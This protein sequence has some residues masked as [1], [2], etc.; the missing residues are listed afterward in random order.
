MSRDCRALIDVGAL[1]HNLAAVRRLSPGSPVMAVVK[2]NAYGHG[3]AIAA[4]ALA[5][6]DAFAVASLEEALAVRAAGLSQPVVL[7]EGVSNRLALEAALAQSFEVV[8]HDPS[9]LPLLET[10]DAAH[11]LTVWLK[12][13]SGMNRLGFRIEDAHAVWRLLTALPGVRQPI[14]LMTH[15]ANADDP[16]DDFSRVQIQR[17]NDFAA[18]LPGP[19]SIA[20]SAGIAAWPDSHA[21]WVRPGI[22]LYGVSPLVNGSGVDHGLRPVMTVTTRLIAVKQLA[23]SD[24]VGY[25]GAWTAPEAMPIGIAAI[26][27]GDGYPRQAPNG[28]PVLVNGRRAGLVG[29]VSM[30][31]IAVDLRDLEATVGDPVTLWGEGLPIEELARAASMIPYELLCGVTQRVKFSVCGE[32][33]EH[34][35]VLA[36][37][38]L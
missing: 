38:S 30:D 29:R 10:L 33:E 26:G 15:L 4:R 2:A 7:L 14:G 21:G 13:D 11:P 24:R 9:Q 12:V 31:M 8:I 37:E 16:G 6:A 20:N 28:A 27:Y 18:G 36:S 17:F 32:N 25:G 34:N 19:R 35:G 23:A 22:L 1:R 5:G 3:L